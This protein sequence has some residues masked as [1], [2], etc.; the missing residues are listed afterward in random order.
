[1]GMTLILTT[2][3][4]NISIYQLIKNTD[5]IS[6]TK[7]KYKIVTKPVYHPPPIVFFYYEYEILKYINYIT[8]L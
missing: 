7:Y 8:V 1:M 5:I 6:F 4:L 2:S 3:I